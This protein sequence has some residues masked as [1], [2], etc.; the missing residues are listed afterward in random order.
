MIFVS[1]ICDIKVMTSA[2]R[3]VLPETLQTQHPSCPTWQSL[4]VCLRTRPSP[5][6]PSLLQIKQSIHYK[7]SLNTTYINDWISRDTQEVEEQERWCHHAASIDN[8]LINTPLASRRLH[9]SSL[10]FQSHGK[11]MMNQEG[12]IVA[13][14]TQSGSKH[15]CLHFQMSPFLPS[16]LKHN[17]VPK[18]PLK[19]WQT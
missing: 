6:N 9:M 16:S 13:H 15:W 10:L 17:R 11:C 3:G 8:K 4:S 5:L 7:S 2:V 14:E 18:C 19:H 12:H 1:Q